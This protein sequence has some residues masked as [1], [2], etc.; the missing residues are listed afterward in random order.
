MFY[1]CPKTNSLNCKSKTQETSSFQTQW[2]TWEMIWLFFV[3]KVREAKINFGLRP[4]KG[5]GVRDPKLPKRSVLALKND[6]FGKEW[7]N[8]TITDGGITVDFWII[9]VYT[10]NWSSNS[11]GSSNSLG[12]SNTWG[13][14]NSSCWDLGNIWRTYSEP[15][16]NLVW[17]YSEPTLNLVW[18]LSEPSLN[19]VWT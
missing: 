16:L 17:T 4:T 15:I 12:S 6:L 8:K 18:T 19:L 7:Q 11:W 13:S 10:S 5:G 9:K 2:F 3:N 14:S 1:S